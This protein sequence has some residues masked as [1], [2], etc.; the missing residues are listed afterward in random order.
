MKRWAEG[1][2]EGEG[3]EEGKGWGREE[4]DPKVEPGAGVMTFDGGSGAGEGVI[5]DV[6]VK[7]CLA[8]MGVNEDV[9]GEGEG[10]KEGEA[11][12]E[13][14]W[15]TEENTGV[16]SGKGEGCKG[17]C[18]AGGAFRHEG[19]G[20]GGKKEEP[21]FWVIEEE[22]SQTQDGDKRKE[23]EKGVGFADAGGVLKAEGAEEKEGAKPS[24]A[25]ILTAE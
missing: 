21:A 20:E 16:E 13:G 11:G 15:L 3:V 2:G 6:V 9:P 25:G 12:G 24:G 5:A 23:A 8:E 4:E 22:F 7:G 1:G 14:L 18:Q 10:E 19:G 17:E